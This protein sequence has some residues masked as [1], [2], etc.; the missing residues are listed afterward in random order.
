MKKIF[1]QPSLAI[2]D[3][4]EPGSTREKPKM[5]A[6]KYPLVTIFVAC[7][8]AVASG[9]SDPTSPAGRVRQETN[10]SDQPSPEYTIIADGARKYEEAYNK[11]DAKELANR[12]TEDVDYIDQDGSGSQWPRCNAET[13]ERQFPGEPRSENWQSPLRR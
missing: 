4:D 7:N 1:P 13:P 9:A 2:V 12:Y 5:K 11:G 8:L 3:N 6:A 10:S